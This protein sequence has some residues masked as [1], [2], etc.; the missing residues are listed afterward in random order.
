M[1]FDA[2]THF[3]PGLAADH[4]MG[5]VL[6]GVTA[7]DLVSHLDQAG[8][9][10]AIAF[11][12]SWQGGSRGE[13]FIDPNYQRAN[14]A[15]AEGARSYPDRLVGF[16]RVN[17]KFGSQAVKELERCFVE[18]GFRGLHLNNTHEWFSPLHV[19]LLSPLLERCEAHGAPVSVHTWFYPSQAYPWIELVEAFPKVRFIFAH[20]GYRQWTDAVIVAE[21]A[22]NVYLETSLQLPAT[23]KKLIDQL[24]PDRV[25]FGSNAPFSYADIELRALGD[26]GLNA[27]DL[28]KV[29]GENLAGLLGLPAGVPVAK[30]KSPAAAAAK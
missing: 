3:G 13:D 5:P 7:A 28:A 30:T 12:P 9:E 17:P 2:H 23:V 25:L 21:R 24:G 20:A 22:V 27:V 6:N 18:Y 26:L 8:I 19:K 11:A 4:P 15:I 1:N 16:A 29:R 10:R 14:A